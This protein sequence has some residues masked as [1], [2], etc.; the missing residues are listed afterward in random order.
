MIVKPVPLIVMLSPVMRTALAA[1]AVAV[2]VTWMFVVPVTMA[3]LL[4]P[5]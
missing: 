3:P 4:R 5:L 1:T 2:T